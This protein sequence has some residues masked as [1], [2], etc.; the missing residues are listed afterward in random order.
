MHKVFTII[1]I[2]IIPI[3]ANI[4]PTGLAE[5]PG[6]DVV[7]WL[8]WDEAVALNE[9][10]PKKLFIDVYT[11]WCGYCK[12]MDRTTFIDSNIVRYLNEHFYAIKLNAEKEKEIEFRNVKFS[13]KKAGSRQVHTL[14]YSLLEGKMSYPSFV[15][16]DENFER[17]AI[18]PG[19]KTTS[20]L[21]P[22][23]KFSA[24]EKYKEMT[25][26]E[27]QKLK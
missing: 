22:E 11:D 12:K 21:M 8:S 17:I 24:E 14:A 4:W 26:Q 23:L 10:S 6:K 9:Q 18:S 1:T 25:W 19:F 3:A 7:Q 16:M 2:A 20:M 5:I 13:L 27:Y 15:M